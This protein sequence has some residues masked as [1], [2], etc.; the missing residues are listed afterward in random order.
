MPL[1]YAALLVLPLW[2]RRARAQAA[3]P[4]ALSVLLVAF[5]ASYLLW[6]VLSK[7]LMLTIAG[8]LVGAGAALQVTRLMG[9]LLYGVQPR[10]PLSFGFASIVIG[11]AALTACVVPALRLMRTDPVIALRG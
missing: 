8:V 1:A 2:W 11:L 4:Q 10:D 9:Y 7:G 3:Q 5:A 6:L